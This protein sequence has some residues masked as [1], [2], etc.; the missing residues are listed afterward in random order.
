MILIR[1]IYWKI[2]WKLLASPLVVRNWHNGYTIRLPRSGSAAQIFYRRYSEPGIAAW[3]GDHLRNGDRFVDIGA[4]V[5]EYSL[6]AASAIQP[7][8]QIIALEP[9]EDLC[10]IIA[11]NFRANNLK[12]CRVVHGAL[13]ERVGHCKVLSDNKTKGALITT[14]TGGELINMVDLTALVGDEP[15][16]G[17]TWIKLDAAGFEAQCL[18]SSKDFVKRHSIH[19]IVKAYNK[20]EVSTR[21]P[22]IQAS[23]P[24]IMDSIG[25][26]CFI[27]EGGRMKEWSRIVSGYGDTVICLP[28]GSELNP[29]QGS[30]GF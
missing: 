3:M 1:K 22:E 27:Y 8:G 24:E 20:H 21:F 16:N 13:G 25:Y 12:N 23:I 19:L 5:G 18:M 11:D 29:L 15:W 14:G 9:Q 30:H 17:R 4:H 26:Q 28:E 6:I 2:R 10:G 7:G